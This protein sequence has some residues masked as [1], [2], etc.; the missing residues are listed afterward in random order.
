M[1]IRGVRVKKNQKIFIL[2]LI[3]M[4]CISIFFKFTSIVNSQT[5]QSAPTTA[6]VTVSGCL[7]QINI[8]Y[9]PVNFTL[10][11]GRLPGITVSKTNIQ[12]YLMVDMT[13]NTNINWDAFI[14]ASNLLPVNGVGSPIYPNNITVWTNDCGG[15][16][17]SSLPATTLDYNLKRLCS[18]IPSNSGF[19]LY[20]NL[21]I[22]IAQY[23]NTYF[24][25][26][27]I[28][29]NSTHSTGS[30][31]P[32]NVTWFGPNNSTVSIITS[33]EFYW[34]SSTVPIMFQTLSPGVGFTSPSAN[35]TYPSGTQGGFPA[36]MTIG[37]NTN[38]YTDIYIKGT[39]LI[40]YSGEA[41]NQHYN[42]TIGPNG[43]LTYSNATSNT[44]WPSYIKH[45]NYS[46]YAPPYVGDFW[47]WRVVRNNTN[48]T[49]FWNISVPSLAKQGNYGGGITAT[50]VD[51]GSIPI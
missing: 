17:P 32:Y 20:F 6:N 46:F 47:N 9:Y 1:F 16:T 34:D 13:I 36:N 33:L 50:A 45:V 42:I 5:A 35:A 38:I 15:G 12:P 28:Y 11:T 49:S 43:N 48:V 31:C 25:N 39:D 40:G 26:I 21:S 10:G 22:P 18:E 2:F 44:T 41:F 27:T 23:N 37:R 8:T 3:I 14:N 30:T 4:F 24:G 7:D 51:Q 19:N 29:V